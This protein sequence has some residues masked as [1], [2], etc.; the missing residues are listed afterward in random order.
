MPAPLD[1]ARVQAF[2][3]RWAGKSGGERATKD[4]FCI[5]L[6][7]AL[8][9]ERPVPGEGGWAGEYRFEVDSLREGP[10]GRRAW[11]RSTS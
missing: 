5:E 7:E 3:D 6:V 11:A 1:L 10:G 9:L 2:V 8:G 4:L